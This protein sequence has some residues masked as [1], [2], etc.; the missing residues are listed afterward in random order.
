MP[1]NSIK[2]S[3]ENKQGMLFGQN[4]LQNRLWG[5][6]SKNLASDSASA[7]PRHNGCQFSGKTDNF[8]FFLLKFASK[9]FW[10]QNFKNLRVGSEL[11]PERYRV[12]QFSGK[13]D[14]FDFFSPHL[15]KKQFQGQN[16]NSQVRFWNYNLQDTACAVFRQNG[17]L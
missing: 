1:K 9:E 14:N 17:Q 15:P 2:V 10:R 6:N 5:W 13:T 7:L 12:C 3:N 11:A 16:F 8:V 4:F